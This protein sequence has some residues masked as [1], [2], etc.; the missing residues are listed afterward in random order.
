MAGHTHFDEST[1]EYLEAIYRL[2][3]EGPG[4]T[5]SAVASEL[6]VAPASVSGMLKKLASEGLIEHRARGEAKLTPSGLEI[7]VRVIR[8]HRLAECLLTDVLGMSWDE[9][10]SEACRLEHAISSAVEARL[11][12]LLGDPKVC[13]HGLPIPPADGSDPPRPG[14]PLAQIASGE[15]A[16]VHGVTEE[17]PEILRYLGEIGLRPG[18]FVEVIEKAPLGG[19][20]TISVNGS[21]HAISLELARMV[22][23]IGTVESGSETLEPATARA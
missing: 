5:T 22:T 20:V 21:R 19:P 13:P 6:G 17:V 9:V 11:V 2:E 14:V 15:R 10:H 7:A 16:L 1:E 3:R 23:V 18:A 4:V 12:T 8:R